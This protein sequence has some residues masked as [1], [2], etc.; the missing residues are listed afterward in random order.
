MRNNSIILILI[1]ITLPLSAQKSK[2]LAVKQM[3]DAGKFNEAKEAIELAV[4]HPKTADWARTYYT[5]GLLCQ[6]AY[7]Q[8]LE[9][10][11]SK[12]TSL[13]ED[14]LYVAYDSYG[15][16]LELDARERLHN[17]IRQNYFLLGNE[18]R[19]LGT[20]HYAQKEYKEALR[21]FE[22]AIFIG[23]SDLISAKAD[24]NLIYNTAVAAFESRNWEKATKYLTLLHEAAFSPA[25]SL[26]LSKAH[27]NAGD[28]VNSEKIMALSLEQ[29][30]YR[31][32][33]VMYAVNHQVRKGN[34]ETA[35]QILDRALEVLPDHYRFLWARALV[36]EEMDRYDEAIQSFLKAAELSEDRPELF[37]HLG[38]CYYNI[39]VDLR[40]SALEITE[41]VAFGK[42]REEYLEKFREAVRWLERSYALDPNNEKTI[43]RLQ[44]LYFQLQMKD[45]QSSLEQQTG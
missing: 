13:Y 45:K 10:N 36:Y 24:T 18:F 42:A 5:K 35:I 9:K 22:H 30:Q 33:L 43:N 44:Q 41:K 6:T 20:K 29:Y 37:Y 19:K 21:A 39:G 15:K 26:L 2:V 8:G 7:Q 11:N 27:L 17:H 25:T 32:T 4:E 23:E 3:M 1:S 12:F 16:A 38:V 28:T 31:D 14:Q 34:M 40:E